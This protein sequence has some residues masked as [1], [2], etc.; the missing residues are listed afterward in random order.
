MLPLIR[1]EAVEIKKWAT[2]EEAADFFVV[3][4]SLPGVVGINAA[5][6]VG[7]KAA[8]FAGSIAATLG[9]ITPSVVIII[10]IAMFFDDL[11]GFELLRRA[12]AGIRPAVAALIVAAAVKL[13]KTGIKSRVTGVIAIIAFGFAC[14]NMFIISIPVPLIILGAGIFGV[15]LVPLKRKRADDTD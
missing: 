5:T 1:R 15:S 8:G 7:R 2:D 3:G 6:A 14:V 13:L 9:M 11:M 4:Q 12:F 10:L